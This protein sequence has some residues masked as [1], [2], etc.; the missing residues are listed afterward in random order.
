MKP[1]SRP[2]MN[3]LDHQAKGTHD[4]NSRRTLW[5]PFFISLGAL[6]LMLFSPTKWALR[7]ISITADWVFSAGLVWIL[8]LALVRFCQ[9]RVADG[10]KALGV[11]TF[12]FVALIGMG[13]IAFISGLVGDSKDGFAD[14][15][16]LPDGI[17]LAEPEKGGRFDHEP[18]GA[19]DRFQAVVRA[20]LARPGGNSAEAAFALPSLARLRKEHPQLL[21][22]FLAA[23]PGWRVYEER[24]G[25][26]ASRRWMDG[27]AWRMTLHGSYSAFNSDAPRFQVRTT[28][29]FSGSAW[30]RGAQRI[31]PGTN[32]L[33]STRRA[34]ELLLSDVL[35]PVEDLVV[36]LFEGSDAP[37]RRITLAAV[38]EL[39]R[40]FAALLAA[41]DWVH[42]EK[43]LPHGAFAAGAASIELRESFQWGLYNATVRCNPG[44]AGRVYLKAFEI[45]RNYPLSA[46]KLKEATN[47]WVGWS[48]DSS[49]QFLSETHFTIY[50]GDWGQFYGAR[51]EVWFEPDDGSD[52]RKL[53]ERSFKIQGWM[54]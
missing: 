17:A 39:E 25:R 31:T 5:L 13:I 35:I 21:D 46:D 37:E 34:N 40:E 38:E 30:A 6:V 1:R 9:K 27:D 41:P 23:H 3:N 4:Q 44:M 51:F 24:G 43:L 15:L 36:E 12:L 45:T 22:R 42:A 52:E 8:G 7:W 29:G 19:E 48:D 16:K 11:L 10:F 26:F 49:E 53:M 47:E 18:G 33:V 32:I 14:D 2:A 20:A 54:R 28:L 50:E